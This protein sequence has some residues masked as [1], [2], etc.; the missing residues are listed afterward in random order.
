MKT[1]LI[2]GIWRQNTGL[3]VLL[4]VGAFGFALSDVSV[5]RDRFV[6]PAFAN[7][8]WGLPAYFASQCVIAYTVH[9][10]AGG[11]A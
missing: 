6:E 3:V 10:V 11:A 2:D 1:I 9:G 8:A 5:A 7:G 4:G